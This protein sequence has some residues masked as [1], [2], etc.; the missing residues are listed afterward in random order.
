[1]LN[2]QEPRDTDRLRFRRYRLD[3]LANVM[4][5]FADEDAKKWYPTK[6]NI[7]ESRQWIQWNLDNYEK[8]G[9]GLWVFEDRR[10]GSFL[11]DCGLTYQD[12][13]GESLIELGYHIQRTHRGK[14]FASE[15]A[16]ACLAFGFENCGAGQIC[17]IVDPRN[18]ASIRVAESVHDSQRSFV[19]DAGNRRNLYWT[20]RPE[21]TERWD[22]DVLAAMAGRAVHVRFAR[23]T[24]AMCLWDFGEDELVDRALAASDAE[25]V[26]IQRVASTYDDPTYPLPRTGQI[27]HMHVMVFAAIAFFEGSVRP[28]KR[29]RRRPE[30]DRP[31]GLPPLLPDLDTGA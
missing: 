25:L 18:T 30:K 9:F 13:E 21:S 29:N 12:V 8:H 7:D 1:M 3:D 28:L 27:A 10:T 24:L 26:A 16:R 14:G 31:A 20:S 11:G 2:T 4:K 15:A 6:S 5:M 23:T 19:N 22:A 17:S